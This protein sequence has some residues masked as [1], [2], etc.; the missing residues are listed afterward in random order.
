MAEGVSLTK[1]V[2]KKKQAAILRIKLSTYSKYLPIP[3]LL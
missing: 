3:Y 2:G 1:D